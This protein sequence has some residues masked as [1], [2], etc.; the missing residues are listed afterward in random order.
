MLSGDFSIRQLTGGTVSRPPKANTG[1][2][3]GGRCQALPSV[4]HWYGP[5]QYWQIWVSL[6][7]KNIQP[8]FSVASG[9]AGGD[10]EALVSNRFWY[11]R[12]AKPQSRRL[13]LQFTME[14]ALWDYLLPRSP[15]WGPL[16][17]PDA[18]NKDRSDSSSH[19]PLKREILSLGGNSCI[20]S[21]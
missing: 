3:S 18:E 11:N 19:W 16:V 5:L 7:E 14:C 20:N 17:R 2:S 21:L 10:Q 15:G 13:G 8:R 1:V 6:K 12:K 9:K 4:C